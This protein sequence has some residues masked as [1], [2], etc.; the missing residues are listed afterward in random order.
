MK[1][2][3]VYGLFAALLA[4]GMTACSADEGT[5]EGNDALPKITI[6]QYEPAVPYNPDNDTQ[7]RFAANS[8]TTAA[9][10]LCEPTAERDARLASL[11]EAGYAD[12]VVSNGTQLTG[13][14]GASADDVIITDL[15]G[16][17]TISAV[18]VGNNTKTIST[19]AFTGLQWE[20]ITTGTYY[21]ATKAIG[22][23]PVSNIIGITETPTTLQI[24]TTDDTLY[25][26]K[27]L[28]ATGY[29]LKINL[30]PDYTDTDE[31]GTYTFFRIAAQTTPYNTN[32]G[33]LGIRDVGYWQGNDA[34]IT[35]G[36]YESGMYEDGYCFILATYYTSAG[37]HG[38]GYDYFEPDY[39]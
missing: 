6:F 11:G 34:F 18:A 5:Y 30:L 13:I 10:Y 7:L 29:H 17:Y 32:Y 31:D 9:Y 19:A 23:T 24:C 39:E 28:Y 38:Y 4:V 26:F 2:K 20:T 1:L 37:T 8:P 12:Y 22:G 3:F 16:P 15:M 25:R 27:D 33:P 35:E 14:N 21:F 36:G